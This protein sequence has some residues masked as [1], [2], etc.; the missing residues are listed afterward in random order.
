MLVSFVYR[1][2]R[3]CLKPRVAHGHDQAWWLPEEQC[4]AVLDALQDD[5]FRAREKTE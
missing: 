3:E 5:Y 4:V 1:L 2:H